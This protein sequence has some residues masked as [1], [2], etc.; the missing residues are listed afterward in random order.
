MRYRLALVAVLLFCSPVGAAPPTVSDLVID[1]PTLEVGSGSQTVT[2]S[3]SVDDP[4]GDLDPTKTRITL[5]YDD[6]TKDK[7]KPVPDG[8]GRVSEEFVVDTAVAQVVKVRVNNKDLAG[9]KTKLK[10]S[11]TISS[12]SLP[13]FEEAVSFGSGT[14]PIDVALGD[15][16][17]D[18]QLDLVTADFDDGTVSLLSG[19]GMGGFTAPQTFDTGD[20]NGPRALLLH[21]LNGDGSL[22]MAV[23]NSASDAV[24]VLLSTGSGTFSP[25]ES[26]AVGTKPL[27]IAVGDIDGDG[28]PDLATISNEAGNDMVSIL[29]GDGTG[30]FTDGGIVSTARGERDK[31]QGLALGML[32]GDADLDLAV[33]GSSGTVSLLWG[34][35]AGMFTLADEI[36]TGL[37]AF[38]VAIEDINAD[39]RLDLV[40]VD[41]RSNTVSVLLN[42]DES[43]D[44][45]TTGPFDVGK[46]P[47][48]VTVADLNDDGHP[49]L[50]SANSG[51]NDLSVL[52]GDGSGAFVLGNTLAV[53]VTPRAVAAG[54]IDGNGSLDLVTADWSTNNVSIILLQE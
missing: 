18:G 37:D 44:F 25:A 41:S 54:D 11:I 45:T 9:E 15:L 53:G 17:G 48:H 26:F 43:G 46:K 6:G 3:F 23:A 27:S 51:S 38:S 35:G 49:D 30:Q 29:L 14:Y 22:D 10:P 28:N 34:D 24:F 40:V 13:A 47:T 33:V 50:A 4:D 12:V 32:N 8:D 31:A 21:D 19:D 5:K 2:I 52:L 1:P 20:F 39:E 42:Q 7:V 36:Q 16:D